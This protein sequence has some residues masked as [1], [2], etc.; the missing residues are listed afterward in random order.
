MKKLRSLTT[1]LAMS[2]PVAVIMVGCS[3]GAETNQ[4]AATNAP[5]ASKAP[6]AP[7]KIEWMQVGWG[8][9]VPSSDDFVKT[10][11]DKKLGTNLILTSPAT[12]EDYQNQL[13]VRL[14][15]GTAPDVYQ[16]L[17]R[18]SLLKSIAS[19]SLLDLT[20][21]LKTK[22]KPFADFVGEETLNNDKVD[23]KLYTI[24]KK[25]GVGSNS[26]W[27]RK[28]WLDN[29]NLKAPVTLDDLYAVAKAFTNDDPDK[30]GKKDTYAI[31]GAG[32]DAFSV[33][34]GAF[35]VGAPTAN[36]SLPEIYIKDNKMVS[37]LYDPNMKNALAFIK[38]MIDEGLVDPELLASTGQQYVQKAIQGKAGMGNFS[39]TDLAKDAPAKQIKEVNPK[40]EW[41]Q[42]A[43]PKG[44]GGQYDVSTG[45][46]TSFTLFGI[47]KAL[48]KDT[49]K[50]DKIF[51]YVNY[52][53]TKEGNRLVS[54][55]VEGRH[56]TLNGDK[57]VPTDLLA[58][59]GAYTWLYQVTGRP[60]A[61]YLQTKF[62]TQAPLIDFVQKQPR[63]TAYNGLLNPP[64]DFMT[65]D[66][67]RF[68][69]EELSKFIYGKTSLDKYD[70]FL[71]NLETKFK[72]NL[73]LDGA[74]KRLKELGYIN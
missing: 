65:A 26:Y 66:A 10:E 53:S 28:D 69:K 22:L 15:G 54:Y 20:P 46:G 74:Q 14:A 19:D 7:V 9:N 24:T 42:I 31:T 62:P 33:I 6:A 12:N 72:Y 30:N 73:Y 38:K 59:E 25:P 47:P 52:I 71:K 56:Y 18:D 5:A 55:G 51:E 11:L 44:P 60:E 16:I 68:I 4:T 70:E 29:L 37:S 48:E 36:N 1:F 50:L 13:N 3:N 40:A 41:M 39:W 64:A 27:L 17:N 63:M 61:E 2:I 32:F 45:K 21:Y 8:T 23:G 34:Y 35:G 49:A 57:V 43:P 67:T 58:K